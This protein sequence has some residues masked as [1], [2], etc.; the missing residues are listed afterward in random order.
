MADENKFLHLGN[1]NNKILY[2]KF[3][4][5]LEKKDIA[6]NNKLLQIF[7][8]FD[9]DG[10]G[11]IET[12]NSKGVNE[13]QSLWNAVRTSATKNSNSI[14]ED[15]EAQEFLVN[16][17]YSTGKSLADNQVTASDLFAF[18]KALITP[19]SK[20]ANGVKLE[21]LKPEDIVEYTPEEIEDI[22]IQ[23]VTVGVRQA[24]EVFDAQK[25]QQGKISD[26]V[27]ETK[28]TFDTEYAS[29][30]VD[31]YLMNEELCAQLLQ[32]AKED[33]LSEKEYLEAKID[34]AMKLIQSLEKY[35]LRTE[36]T[37]DAI[38]ISLSFLTLGIADKKETKNSRELK[39]QKLELENLKT[40]LAKL[41]PEEINML[42]SQLLFIEDNPKGNSNFDFSFG[43]KNN[44]AKPQTVTR[45]GVEGE[46]LHISPEEY[47]GE[48]A[49]N[50][51]ESL[52][53]PYAIYKKMTFEEVFE[54][55]RGVQYNPEAIMDYST[56]EA[57][58]QFLVGMH[59]RNEAIKNILH[60]ATVAVDGNNKY[61]APQHDAIET[62]NQNLANQI[63]TA[64]RSLY[65]KN[66]AEAQRVID[67]IMGQN[68]GI[69]VVA[70]EQGNFIKLEIYGFKRNSLNLDLLGGTKLEGTTQESE[71][72]FENN[73]FRMPVNAYSL[74]HLSKGL[75]QKLE[76]N[77]QT[78]LKGKTLDEYSAEVKSAYQM[79]YGAEN[80]EDMAS[81][82]VQSQ[83]E[84]VQNTK[85]VVQGL[86]MVAMVA[87]QL[88]PVG[89][90]AATALIV[91]KGAITYGGMLTSTLGSVG[92]SAVENYTKAG[93]PTEEDKKAMLQELG[94][95]L[96]LVGSGMGIGKGSEAIFRTLVMKNC[97]KLI[98][99]AAEV[100][101]DATASLLA[102]YAITGQIDLSGEGIAQLQN[103]LVGIIGAKG[104]RNC[105]NTH[106]GDITTRR[107][108]ETDVKDTRL[109]RSQDYEIGKPHIPTTTKNNVEVKG[110]VFD[111]QAFK[112]ICTMEVNGKEIKFDVAYNLKEP[113][114]LKLQR[115]FEN[116]DDVDALLQL[117][118]SL[119]KSNALNMRT[120]VDQLERISE[121]KKNN[122]NVNIEKILNNEVELT[123]NNREGF[124][125]LNRVINGEKPEFLKNIELKFEQEHGVKIHLPNNLQQDIV[126]ETIQ[127][128]NKAIE[129]YKS[130]GK[131]IPTD[132]YFTN[133]LID[134]RKKTE[135]YFIK[136]DSF[137]VLKATNILDGADKA[138]HTFFHE[139][140][141]YSDM[142][143]IDDVMKGKALGFKP[144]GLDE[145]GK[146]KLVY[147][148]EL[149][150]RLTE[151][152][153]K[154]ISNYSAGDLNEF[155][156]EFGAM[157]LEGKISL[158]EYVDAND[159]IKYKV[160][161]K[162]PYINAD[163]VEIK[164]SQDD[165]N[166]IQ[167]LA[168][169]Y[170]T[171]AGQDFTVRKI[172][173]AET[174]VEQ[175]KHIEV[176][177]STTKAVTVKNLIND[178]KTEYSKTKRGQ[179]LLADLEDIEYKLD[180]CTDDILLGQI[181]KE[182]KA[183]LELVLGNPNDVT[184]ITLTN[185]SRY[186]D[187]YN[188][189]IGNY[190][191]L[192][193]IDGGAV[194]KRAYFRF[195]KNKLNDSEF[196]NR[197][198]R[199]TN[200]N[201][202]KDAEINDFNDAGRFAGIIDLCE[203]SRTSDPEIVKYL[204]ENYY[205]KQAD[206]SPELASACLDISSNF[207][208][209]IFLSHQ[210][211]ENAP[212]ALEIIN[213]EL[214]EWQSKSNGTATL[215]QVLNFNS[216]KREYIDT[217]AVNGQ[218]AAGG[219]A[220][221][222]NI[223]LNSY[224]DRDGMS[225]AA[226]LRH[227]ITHLNDKRKGFIFSDEYN[228]CEIC[229]NETYESGRFREEFE[230]AGISE[231]YI[232]YAHTN[233]LEFIAVAAQGDMTKYSPEFKKMLV[234]FGMPEYMFEMKKNDDALVVK[235]SNIEQP[236]SQQ[237]AQRNTNP[238]AEMKR[239]R[240]IEARKQQVAQAQVEIQKEFTT[241]K[242]KI[243]ATNNKNLI[244][245]FEHHISEG[246]LLPKD[247]AQIAE[248]ATIKNSEI[249]N[250]IITKN[251]NK[252]GLDID[253]NEIKMLCQLDKDLIAETNTIN[254]EG[255]LQAAIN[256]ARKNNI[257][258]DSDSYSFKQ[259]AK[260]E[261]FKEYIDLYGSQ[262][263]E[264][265]IALYNK[266][267]LADKSPEITKISQELANKY[268]IF[269]FA[270]NI[271]ELQMLS[272]ELSEIATASNGNAKLPSVVD[273]SKF[274]EHFI[275]KS[276]GGIS[277]RNTINIDGYQQG[278]LRHELIHQNDPF[279]N[280][281]GDGCEYE[282]LDD[283]LAG[284]YIDEFRK[285]GIDENSI[286]YA[287]TSRS[288]YLAVLAGQGD[289][290][291][292]S[293]EFKQVLI[294]HLGMPEWVFNMKALDVV[295]YLSNSAKNLS[296][297]DVKVI[298]VPNYGK[299]EITKYDGN[300]FDYKIIDA[301]TIST[302]TLGFNDAELSN[303]YKKAFPNVKVPTDVNIDAMVFLN[304]LDIEIASQFDAHGI[305]KVSVTDQ[306]KQLNSILINGIDSSRDLYTAPLAAPKGVGAGLGTGGGH[307]YRDG[308]FI[309]VSGKGKT[310]ATGGIET[311][312]V[313]DAY[314]S[315]IE[316][317]R[318][319]FPNIKFV[320]AEDA[321]DFFNRQ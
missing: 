43:G 300:K 243:Y 230:R 274:N 70:D 142:N 298:E 14:F 105:L 162:Q 150:A 255:K 307:A 126:E 1:S 223:S 253:F 114:L 39:A 288:E 292:C 143:N 56:K 41:S 89:G 227:E 140:V 24:R 181:E 201:D 17:V 286:K 75:Q 294:E 92:V 164:L 157:L 147:D 277:S 40:L 203:N 261:S 168:D 279:N 102:D 115:L 76:D 34:L 175:P 129:D 178:L 103:I 5:K 271:Q 113:E 135:G 81:A 18:L 166:K 215:P 221:G 117:N 254:P 112:S 282:L 58:L 84:D 299:I 206:I 100:G 122:P 152:T 23:T 2:D 72:G 246:M 131:N 8:F 284:K 272:K 148:E 94:T 190:E 27:N 9:K 87:G 281:M 189:A 156:A 247:I 220:S 319:K 69:K 127:A 118:S 116:A 296:A 224:T 209:K 312:I 44:K 170:T 236:L 11:I 171:V 167:E 80:A 293:P 239:K 258:L 311:V 229:S 225:F 238:I 30:R 136:D 146:L 68:S 153:K 55:E 172:N 106:A 25:A 305:A 198:E 35:S 321:A 160:H 59:N 191:M 38:N 210:N 107:I 197:A 235:D 250:Q 195:K 320:K 60:D 32:R 50:S 96:A 67:E 302:K 37:Q 79:A 123:T 130:T 314:Y 108:T 306:L 169:Y 249:L 161:V 315:I 263:K 154:Y 204:Y 265:A 219:L 174:G 268:G 104:A 179:N 29:S 216:T 283:V 36:V 188:S 46:Y 66:A 133:L 93:G 304:D 182:L 318:Q 22:S 262:N 297:G 202:I 21:D 260:F 95:S 251:S 280:P 264:F 242:E 73:K 273:F 90:Q 149:G 3:K 16:S 63:E 199:S 26:F 132:I 65:S 138:T 259:A 49:P 128:L 278:T 276:A 212:K 110:I 86:G 187:A 184:D 163:G 285:A 57:H 313:N 109:P 155:K 256:M 28:E 176:S 91:A 231:K 275:T 124:E 248:L 267:Y 88:I 15:S 295:T 232:K 10:N 62:C 186:L 269:A 151:S 97:P 33:G 207:E 121:F 145:N 270:N 158:E 194:D 82:F 7:N 309:I 99:F 159:N 111:R 19:Q 213:K 287:H 47:E 237:T 54:K 4:G 51:L 45:Y 134:I 48:A 64:F 193:N 228:S 291:K 98:A 173:Q 289:L 200:S 316:D 141:H 185:V 12:A 192:Y 308:S 226:E 218:G 301:T 196:V 290:S 77:Y 31:R 101:V 144:A 52:S 180:K 208:T 183:T 257:A 71:V 53:K 303:L 120:Y 234:E 244:D 177:S 233:S 252:A 13:M 20:Q 139:A 222:K 125:N 85:A 42:I 119:L 61:G 240:K 137:I 165:L 317:L 214:S 241:A 83:Q 78:A 245:F 310:L 205:L 211:I 74:V 6:T 217:G 266:Y